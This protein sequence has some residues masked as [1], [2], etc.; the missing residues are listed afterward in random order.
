MWWSHHPRRGKHQV[1]VGALRKSGKRKPATG[2][3][4]Y[5]RNENHALALGIVFDFFVTMSNVALL[6]SFTE[7]WCAREARNPLNAENTSVTLITNS[8][9]P[10]GFGVAK[11]PLKQTSQPVLRARRGWRRESAGPALDR[12]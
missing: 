8:S 5:V 12:W 6:R 9:A 2:D 3:P 4:C 11:S 10:K 7:L 1:N